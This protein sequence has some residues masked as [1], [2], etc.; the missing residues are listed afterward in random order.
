MMSLMTLLV[1]ST[2]FFANH[3]ARLVYQLS[4]VGYLFSRLQPSPPFTKH[5]EETLDNEEE[6]QHCQD[7]Y[8][9]PYNF[10]VIVVTFMMIGDV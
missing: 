4:N 1:M 8:S 5:V 6:C 7:D 2:Q 9:F 3:F 10:V